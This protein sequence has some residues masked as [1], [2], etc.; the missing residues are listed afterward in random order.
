MCWLEMLFL[1]FKTH[2]IHLWSVC[3]EEKT[4]ICCFLSLPMPSMGVFTYSCHV[5]KYASAM[6][7]MGCGPGA[8]TLRVNSDGWPGP[9]MA[10]EIYLTK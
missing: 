10:K 6:D 9:G 1:Q 4:P 5:G 7:P 3:I 8:V 2:G